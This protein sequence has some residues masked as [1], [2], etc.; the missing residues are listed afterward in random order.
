MTAI[1]NW[2]LEHPYISVPL[3]IVVLFGLYV[4]GLECRRILFGDK[5]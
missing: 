5:S 1:L 3:G 4:I 2:A